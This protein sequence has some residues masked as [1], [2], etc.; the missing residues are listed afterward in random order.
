VFP[1]I[2]GDEV[3]A[4]LEYFSMEV[5]QADFELLE[6]ITI[7]GAQLG[8]VFERCH[9]EETLRLS[10][11][12]FVSAFHSSPDAIFIASMRE[13][14]IIEVNDTFLQL[15]DYSRHEVLSFKDTELELW[16]EPNE[17]D[18][19]IDELK[20]DDCIRGKEI[21]FFVSRKTIVN[22]QISAEVINIRGNEYM[23]VTVR[24]ITARKL[25]EKELQRYKYIVSTTSNLM[26]LVDRDYIYRAVN[27]SYLDA[28][29]TKTEDIVDHKISEIVGE[30]RFKIIVKK[31]ID[32]Y[33]NG[34]VAN[35]ERRICSPHRGNE[36]LAVSYNPCRESDD[37]VT[38]A[39]P[40]ERDITQ[41]KLAKEALKES[42]EHL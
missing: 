5:A 7:L 33:L 6:I 32:R 14:G 37:P 36:V 27:Q 38:G 3:I 39:V 13:R 40:A 12:K 28:F 1:V 42:E 22:Y 8:R 25:A 10:E 20:S 11:E 2:V 18:S 29:D 19:F 34:E 30:N 17:R 4:V 31:D 41:Q 35:V 26:V 21:D 9:A 15:N 23:I 16:V 24:D